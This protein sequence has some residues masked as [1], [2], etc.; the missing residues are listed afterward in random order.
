M[1][2]GDSRLEGNRLAERFDRF[3]GATAGG[4][5]RA[6]QEMGGIACGPERENLAVQRLGLLQAAFAMVFTRGLQKEFER[7]SEVRLGL[8]VVGLEFE[9]TAITGDGVLEIA[10]LQIRAA[11]VRMIIGDVRFEGEG[12]LHEVDGAIVVVIENRER[13]EQLEGFVIAR[14]LYE[15]LPTERCRFGALSGAEMREGGLHQDV[16]RV[17]GHLV[18]F[19]P[20]GPFLSAQAAGLGMRGIW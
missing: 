9:S 8:R 3:D 13:A 19:R 15:N 11:E 20:D 12:L 4:D 17:R 2:D 1:K 18:H 14:I 10:F 6:E 16:G 5:E 7:T